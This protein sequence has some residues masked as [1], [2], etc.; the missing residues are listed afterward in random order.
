MGLFVV[1]EGGEGSGKTTQGQAL[2]HRLTAAGYPVTQVREPGGTPTGEQ[3]RRW[4]KDTNH[5]EPI[6]ELFLFSAAR[7]ALVESVI[8]PAQQRDEV[9][10]CDRYVYSTLAYQSYGRGLD[11]QMVTRINEI[12]T[13]GLSPEL[14]VLLDLAP[15]VGFSRK[16]G[17]QLD[18]FERE[19]GD[20]HQ[21]VRQGF[22]ELARGDPERW[23]VLDSSKTRESVSNS[24]WKRV[25]QILQ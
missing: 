14:V 6:T 11:I 7:T 5:I 10:I 8:R 23:L 4:L 2:E 3:I 18:R 9:V 15:E 24:I 19:S 17:Q 25:E 22:L 12:S 13:G 1:I 20:F 16:A 21:R